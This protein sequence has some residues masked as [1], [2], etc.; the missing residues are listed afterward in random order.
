[1]IKNVIIVGL[2]EVGK[3]I[4]RVEQEAGNTIF[5]VEQDTLELVLPKKIDA[6][7]VC[8]PYGN[9]FEDSVIHYMTG[10][11]PDITIIHSTISPGATETIKAIT[12]MNVVHSPIRGVHPELYEGIKTFPKYVGGDEH[13]CKVATEHLNSIK[14]NVTTEMQSKETEFLKILSTTYYAWNIMYADFVGKLCKENNLD[15]DKVYTQA[16][17]DYNEGYE[18]LDM[19]NVR[20]PILAP[21]KNGIGGHCLMENIVLLYKFNPEF[22]K[23]M[24][25]IGKDSKDPINDKAWLAGEYIGKEKTAQEIADDLNVINDTVHYRL[26]KYG[27]KNLKNL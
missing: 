15:Y 24:L 26:R 9:S 18:K 21:P 7:H 4:K 10:F 27:L 25:K 23:N 1:M 16:N 22:C 17:I 8:I 2:G 20:R 6:M 3:A 5:E 12:N 13:S 19:I 14:I 11:K